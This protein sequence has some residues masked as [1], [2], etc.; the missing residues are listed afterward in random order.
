MPLGL[1]RKLQCCT[2]P[3]NHQRENMQ[4]KIEQRTSQLMP[5]NGQWRDALCKFHYKHPSARICPALQSFR[6][7]QESD[8]SSLYRMFLYK[9]RLTKHFPIIILKNHLSSFDL[10][11]QRKHLFQGVR[12]NVTLFI[13]SLWKFFL[14]MVWGRL[15]SKPLTFPL[16]KKQDIIAVLF[17]L[18]IPVLKNINKIL[19][20]KP[21]F[22]CCSNN[23]S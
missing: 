7:L 18:F 13:F 5:G 16:P 15:L 4:G 20:P 9:F 6:Y 12:S 2:L 1:L 8:N 19:F 17:F 14:V 21:H 11:S 3:S 10:M 22:L 23:I